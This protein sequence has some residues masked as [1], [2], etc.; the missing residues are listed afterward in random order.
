MLLFS[1]SAATAEVVSP[2]SAGEGEVLVSGFAGEVELM[3]PGSAGEEE[4]LFC[5]LTGAAALVFSGSA[6]E[7]ATAEAMASAVV[8]VSAGGSGVVVGGA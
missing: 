7:G 1:E 4:S 5:G 8:G 2:G 3:F 6:G